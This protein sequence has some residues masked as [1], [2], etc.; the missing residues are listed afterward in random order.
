M[1]TLPTALAIAPT[2]LDSQSLTVVATLS[3]ELITAGGTDC[4]ARS[5]FSVVSPDWTESMS[6]L[7]YGANDSPMS[8]RVTPMTTNAPRNTAAAAL[9]RDQPRLRSAMT[10]GANVAATMSATR[11]DAVTV[12]RTPAR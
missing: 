8:R 5:S 10:Y 9:I 3:R 12:P 11:I 7:T 6:W 1:A 2:L 4:A